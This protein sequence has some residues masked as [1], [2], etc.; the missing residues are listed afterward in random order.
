MIELRLF[1]R[2]VVVFG[3]ITQKDFLG[4]HA[5]F[6]PEFRASISATER[7]SGSTF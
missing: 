5:A 2:L 1:V 4:S 3:C 6:T 7:N